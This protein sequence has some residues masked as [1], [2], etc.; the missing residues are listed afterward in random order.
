M[1]QRAFN[2]GKSG[3]RFN[4]K[5]DSVSLCWH[6]YSKHSHTT[7]TSQMIYHRGGEPER[8]MH[9]WFNVMAHNPWITAEFVTAC[10]SMSVV[11]NYTLCSHFFGQWSYWGYTNTFTKLHTGVMRWISCAYEC[12]LCMD[13]PEA[14]STTMRDLYCLWAACL[15]LS[16][17]VRS[18]QA[19]VNLSRLCSLGFL[20]ADAALWQ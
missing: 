11:S 7:N 10:C 16:V 20:H 12:R 19:C 15:P 8:A 18:C 1:E 14:N 6:A 9:C 4:N 17:M 13:L 2:N 5:N 3:R